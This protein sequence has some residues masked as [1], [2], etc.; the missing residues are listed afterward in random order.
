MFAYAVVRNSRPLALVVAALSLAGCAQMPM[1]LGAGANQFFGSLFDPHAKFLQ[2]V[3]DKDWDAAHDYYVAHQAPLDADP[4]YREPLQALAAGFN[5]RSAAALQGSLSKLESLDPPLPVARWPEARRA[6]ADARQALEGRPARVL[7]DRPGFRSPESKELGGRLETLAKAYDGHA[8][9]AYADY[10][11]TTADSPFFS[12]YPLALSTTQ[13]AAVLR[14]ALA[15][16]RM[17]WRNIPADKLYGVF[18]DLAGGQADPALLAQLADAAARGVAEQR[19]WNTPL[20]PAQTLAIWPE[21]ERAVPGA[22]PPFT[23]LVLG[24]D[25][26]A[27]SWS[28]L[29]RE[30]R[31]VTAAALPSELDALA[32]GG[33][34][35]ALV[36]A[37]TPIK[38]HEAE[39]LDVKSAKSRRVT[40]TR[41]VRNPEYDRLQEQ[42]R[43]AERVY[44]QVQRDADNA[45]MQS[46][47]LMRNSSGFASALAV[48]G[49]AGSEMAVNMARDDMET[50][51]REA[52]AA[53]ATKTEKI[54]ENY[55]YAEVTVRHAAVQQVGAYAVDLRQRTFQ[56]W[57]VPGEDA[58]TSRF[59]MHVDGSDENA[60]RLRASGAS[61]A[62]P[63][64]TLVRSEQIIAAMRAAN[65]SPASYPVD[66]L[67]AIM[68]TDLLEF[69]TR[70][71]E[72]EA[73]IGR[74]NEAI[75]TA[76]AK[77]APQPKAP[78][79]PGSVPVAAE[80]SGGS[81]PVTLAHL[82]SRF[83][84]ANA[85]PG[86]E[87][88]NVRN[89][90]LSADVRETMRAVGAQGFSPQR[91]IDASLAQ[92]RQHDD[93][94]RDA[95]A[96]ASAVDAAGITDETFAQQVNSGQLRVSDCS[97][98]RNGSLCAAIAEKMGAIATRAMAAAMQCH[99]RAGTWPR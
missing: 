19:G 62:A 1:D 90:I 38:V 4:K 64:A 39:H 42:A 60:E 77:F 69:D 12:A 95:L 88:R 33:A 15:G 13:R 52:N 43:E 55:E 67:A 63:S 40:G 32:R 48:I 74:Q 59:A 83:P 6:I 16:T 14:G 71:R 92:A 17:D 45:R 87:L 51:R 10:P 30:I 75:R 21:V 85:L 36:L 86:A 41:E 79:S 73:A 8:M 34:S 9:Q 78:A 25:S 80:T 31:P 96:T 76:A 20:S 70:V 2:A 46:Q 23:V 81:C 65:A 98:I 91:G 89:Q 37:S 29:G 66:R 35:H 58:R 50:A 54:Y 93:V 72:R 97:G 28:R 82:R 68:S 18:Q 27:P 56:K 26:A 49:A 3:R 99:L 44:Q 11:H 7:V 53:R 47:Q 61:Y 57:L 24:A 22:Q 5:A 94:A 84:D